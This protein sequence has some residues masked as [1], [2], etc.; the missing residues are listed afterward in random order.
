M[1]GTIK[2][3]ISHTPAPQRSFCPQST[4]PTNESSSTAATARQYGVAPDSPS[5]PNDAATTPVR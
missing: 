1:P 2:A 3:P 5:S 4:K